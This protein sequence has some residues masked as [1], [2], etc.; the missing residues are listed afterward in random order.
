MS[1]IT[2]KRDSAFM[3]RKELE[4]R[5]QASIDRQCKVEALAEEL[6]QKATWVDVIDAMD[7]RM[8]PTREGQVFENSFLDLIR[9]KR[10]ATELGNLILKAVENYF[11]SVADDKL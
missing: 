4:A 9:T 5:H 11:V 3:S 1:T 8:R 7:A 10:D 2:A 6:Q